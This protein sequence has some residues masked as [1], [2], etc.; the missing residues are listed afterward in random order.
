MIES[1]A[2]PRNVTSMAPQIKSRRIRRRS[3]PPVRHALP[4]FVFFLVVATSLAASASSTGGGSSPN[5]PNNSI[6]SP[7]SVK[8]LEFQHP[9]LPFLRNRWLSHLFLKRRVPSGRNS[10]REPRRSWVFSNSS[11]PNENTTTSSEP[12]FTLPWDEIV[13]TSEGVDATSVGASARPSTSRYHDTSAAL[14]STVSALVKS[15]LS[16]KQRLVRIAASSFQIGILLYV[17]HAAW[18]AVAEV[19]EEYSA[20]LAAAGSRPEPLFCKRDHVLQVLAA[21]EKLLEADDNEDHL[22]GAVVDA[23][24]ASKMST[25]LWTVIKRLLFSGLPLRSTPDRPTSVESV[26]LQLTKTEAAILQQCLWTPPPTT[27]KAGGVVNL[28][29]MWTDVAG[30]F[31]VKERMLS[32]LASL[33]G[34]NHAQNAFRGLFDDAE[35]ITASSNQGIL[36]YGPPGCGK[37]LLVRALATT[38]RLPCLTVTPSSLLRKVRNSA[39]IPCFLKSEFIDASCISTYVLPVCGR[40]EQPG[41]ESVLT[42]AKAGSMHPLH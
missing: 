32:A 24:G 9:L 2:L 16:D 13:T 7:I 5:P 40:D 33:R 41:E 28:Q 19:A 4:G 42:G 22:S 34:R 3:D 38:A 1:D 39:S 29:S 18:K 14:A 31:P 27:S 36:L 11:P 26:L 6:R 8:S 20:E 15:V 37:T 35:S 17:A 23:L 12:D 30:L 25:P 21:Y 10:A